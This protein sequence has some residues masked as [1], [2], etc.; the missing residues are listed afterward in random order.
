M[1]LNFKIVAPFRKFKLLTGE[2]AR[3]TDDGE[4]D[5]EVSGRRV[6]KIDS[7]SVNTLVAFPQVSN[8][9]L[10][11]LTS[12]ERGP[13]P[14]KVGGA[15]QLRLAEL[16]IPRVVA[17][18]K[19]RNVQL[20]PNLRNEY[21]YI[22]HRVHVLSTNFSLNFCNS[23]YGGGGKGR[24]GV[25][26]LSEFLQALKLNTGRHECT[27]PRES[28]NLLSASKTDL[29]ERTYYEHASRETLGRFSL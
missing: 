2:F 24:G 12:F 8:R 27:R 1:L 7:A 29:C 26:P 15:P 9:Q 19:H 6:A 10:G 14:P 4:V 11:G 21:I 25:C 18:T 3:L 16:S 23:S 17:A 20:E 22:H 13:V 5:L 28:D